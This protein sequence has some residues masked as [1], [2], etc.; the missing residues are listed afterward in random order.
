MGLGLLHTQVAY[1]PNVEAHDKF[2]DYSSINWKKEEKSFQYTSYLR[3]KIVF[4]KYKN[5]VDLPETS[6]EKYEPQRGQYL[7]YA[8]PSSGSK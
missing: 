8:A 4:P 2:T 5:N 3:K 7:R 1:L 6:Y